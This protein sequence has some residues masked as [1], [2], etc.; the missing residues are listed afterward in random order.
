MSTSHLADGAN[1]FVRFDANA[2]PR[3]LAAFAAN[4]NRVPRNAPLP[5]ARGVILAMGFDDEDQP[6][7]S[8]HLLLPDGEI[9]VAF[10]TARHDMDVI[11][12]WRGLGRDFNL[13]LFIRSEAGHLTAVTPELGT[14]TYPRRIGS[15]LSSR[16]PRFLARRRMPLVP[17]DL[18]PEARAAERCRP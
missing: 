8:L 16:R 7:V 5:F 12:L 1:R 15:P 14:A 6:T 13:P 2:G 17:H 10:H 4:D 3:D 9:G 18:A 11:A